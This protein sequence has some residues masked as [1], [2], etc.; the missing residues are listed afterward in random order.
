MKDV[1][2]E[3]IHLLPVF[4][5]RLVEIPYGVSHPVWI[6]DSDF[7][8]DHHLR[9]QTAAAP[10]GDRELGAIVSQ[11]ASRPLVR[12]RPLWEVT[13]VTG[14]AGDRLGFV[15]KIHHAIADGATAVAQL[16]NVMDSALSP[17]ETEQAPSEPWR[18]EP[19][20]ADMQLLKAAMRA[21]ARN[22]KMLPLLIWRT[23]VGYI[24]LKKRRREGLEPATRPF[25]TNRFAF[26]ASLTPRRDFA[27]TTL[28]LTE[29]RNIKRATN[30]TLNDVVL[31]VCG[32]AM[33]R[34]LA[35]Q[36]AP[37]ERS[38]TASVPV[39]TGDQARRRL[40]GN[41]VS[42]IFAPIGTDVEDPL[43]RLR[44]IHTGM[45]N[46]KEALK[47]RGAEMHDWSE[48]YPPR[49]YAWVV[50]AYSKFHLAD[51]HN[52][53]INMVVSNVPGPRDPLYVDGARLDDIYSVGPILEGIGL[54]ITV[55][56]YLDHMNFS[57]LA[58]PDHGTDVWRIC[59]FL[60][61][62]FEALHDAVESEHEARNTSTPDRGEPTVA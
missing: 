61:T 6:E 53:P 28:P 13:L 62:A 12:T 21:L 23:I 18:P 60:H 51:Y 45:S 26:N 32:G 41:D 29:M 3:R 10:G 31:G 40:Q 33:R 36:D 58:C 52:P 19:I 55:W 11:V 9:I 43:E 56:S 22:L 30:T 16:I 47:T 49:P 2:N 27:M 44:G 34:Y 39:S 24:E 54:N 46:A 59:D 50:R 37:L 35:E 8:I 4:R 20:P 57:A 7:D 5:R 48:I 14:L 42:S 25:S 15:A 1:I 17:T 38:L